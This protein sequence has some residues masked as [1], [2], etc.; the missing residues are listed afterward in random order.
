M[1]ASSEQ[2]EIKRAVKKEE[3]PAT[4]GAGGGYMPG[5]GG[6]VR[7]QKEPDWICP[8]P[9]CQNKNFGWRQVCNRCQVMQGLLEHDDPDHCL[10]QL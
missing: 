9:N 6:P 5:A 4:G 1:L 7:G 3:M 10:C 8:E 2:V